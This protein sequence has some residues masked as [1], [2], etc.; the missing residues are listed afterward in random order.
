MRLAYGLRIHNIGRAP[1]KPNSYIGR[2]GLVDCQ[3]VE[4]A[5]R[6]HI[7]GIGGRRERSGGER[8]RC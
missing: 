2:G 8:P 7:R 4:V 3:R 6:R 5:S 1:R